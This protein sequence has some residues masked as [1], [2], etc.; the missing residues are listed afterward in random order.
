MTIESK[1]DFIDEEVELPTAQDLE[2]KLDEAISL[3]DKTREYR[4]V[5]G[6]IDQEV[7]GRSERY[8][9]LDN[10][11]YGEEML[12]TE[13]FE[14]QLLSSIANIEGA[15]KLPAEE[16]AVIFDEVRE[17]I[18]EI[19]STLDDCTDLPSVTEDDDY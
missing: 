12:R 5:A 18:D 14:S 4:M 10:L 7:I 9:P 8:V 6:S 15:F 1:T 13:S 19:A 11:P 16:Q 2:D 3:L 17:V